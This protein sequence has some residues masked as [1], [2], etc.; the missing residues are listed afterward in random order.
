MSKIAHWIA[1]LAGSLVLTVVPASAWF[2]DSN[3]CSGTAVLNTATGEWYISCSGNSCGPNNSR[4][5]AVLVGGIPG[6]NFN[7]CGCS[8]GNPI[9]PTCCYVAI[10]TATNAPFGN[11]LC[12]GDAPIA[13]SCP[14]RSPCDAEF[15]PN[16]TTE[17][18]G[19]CKGALPP[20]PVPG[21]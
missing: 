11:G 13:S 18:I 8:D 17:K 5:C 3:G 7:F 15:K 21:S 20:Q 16:S 12:Y 14:A 10:D 19:K 1:A 6:S 9:T 4:P 2:G